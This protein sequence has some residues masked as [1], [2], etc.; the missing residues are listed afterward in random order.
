M[1]RMKTENRSTICIVEYCGLPIALDKGAFWC[2]FHFN[3][4]RYNK[5]KKTYDPIPPIASLR[6][7]SLTRADYQ[8]MFSAQEGRCAICLSPPK[9][10]RLAIDHD[11]SCCPGSG[12]CGKCV[13][14]LLCAGCNLQLGVVERGFVP[15]AIRYLEKYG[16]KP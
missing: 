9:T 7:F 6:K 14:G 1:R 16:V 5:T 12:S 10:N 8:Q 11:H 2:E 3:Q 13:R 15:L 4:W